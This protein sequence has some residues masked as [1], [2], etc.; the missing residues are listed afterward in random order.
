[1]NVRLPCLAA[2]MASTALPAL[3]QDAEEPLLT[4]QADEIVVESL[5]TPTTQ[6]AVPNNIEI[7]TGE[8]IVERSDG[9]LT[10]YLTSRVAGFAP[11]NGGIS[12]AS[13]TIRGRSIQVLINGVPRV[14]ELRGFN[15]ELFLI[16]PN[17]I[18][19]VEIIKGST[20]LFG[21]GA[22][23]GLINIITKAAEEPGIGFGGQTRLSF[24]DANF[25]ESLSNDVSAYGQYR[26]EDFGVR[27]DLGGTFTSDFFGG[28]SAPQLP[29]DP[30]LGQGGGD[31]ISRFSLSSTI[32]YTVGDHEFEF[33]A[34][35]IKL[36]QDQD[37]N[38]DFTTDPVSTDFNSPYVGEDVQ[39]DTVTLQAGYR[40]RN[41]ALGDLKISG[42]YSTSD[43]VAAFVP[44]GPANTLVVFSGDPLNPQD[45][46]GQSRL[47]TEQFGVRGSLSKDFEYFSVTGGVDYQHDDITQEN[48][49]GTPL[50]TPLTQ[51]SIAGFVQVDVPVGD[52]IDFRFGVRYEKFFLDV[53]DFTR[54]AIFFFPAALLPAVDVT[55]GSFDYDALVFNVGGVYHATDAL[56]IFAGFSQGFSIPDVG[57][58]TRR[59][60]NPNPFDTTPISFASLQPEAAIVNNYEAGIRYNGGGIRA[61]L[62]GFLSTSDEGTTFDAVTNEISQQKERIWGG[63]FTFEGDLTEDI[64]LG[65][66]VGYQEGR[67]DSDND[68]DIDSY[69]PNNRIVS[70]WTATIYGDYQIMDGF[71]VGGEMVF[72]SGRERDNNFQLEESFS[73]NLNASYE[74]P[75]EAGRVSAGVVNLFNREQ[76]NPTASSVRNF[77][78]LDE[79]RRIW[80]A[81]QVDF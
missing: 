32:D 56:D 42:F 9:N 16:D 43:R 4:L 74:L 31:N 49:D 6:S 77:P 44:V 12:G 41:T 22:T 70:P 29:S 52:V 72:A 53:G 10:R 81:Y 27:F 35:Y 80:L 60:L 17:S 18:D 78:V 7:I 33:N 36:D 21:N 28:G 65:T 50:I 67:F 58:F 26:G 5:R 37:Y 68:G 71:F 63:E 40:N 54:P 51:N 25:G 8:E 48:V 34:N 73:V 66:V 45:P 61:E 38:V 46:N 11:S 39:D 19:R 15:R 24:N 3:A 62:S 69:L 55:G 47:E 20:A 14:S 79:G 1:M 64:T 13:E 76:L 23:G 30:L 59:A 2:L 75:R 57:A